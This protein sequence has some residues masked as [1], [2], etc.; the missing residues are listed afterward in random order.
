MS[1][2]IRSDQISH[3]VVS[4]SLRPHESQHDRSPC[5]SPTPGVHWHS[6]PS[7][8]WCHPAISSS[9]VPFSSCPQSLSASESFPMSQLLNLF[10]F[11]T[12]GQKKTSLVYNNGFFGLSILH[13][14]LSSKVINLNILFQCLE[15]HPLEISWKFWPSQNTVEE[16]WINISLISMK[17]DWGILG[18]S[19]CSAY[20]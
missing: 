19:F 13:N 6:R 9:V 20:S 2:K 16:Y 18:F 8:Q 7:S 1:A 12:T 14:L 4:Y 5:P 11:R 10:K 15:S 3:S 17:R